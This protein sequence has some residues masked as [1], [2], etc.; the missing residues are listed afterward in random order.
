[1]FGLSVVTE[2]TIGCVNYY[3]IDHICGKEEYYEGLRDAVYFYGEKG[4]PS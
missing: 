1:M 2:G 4:N 3:I